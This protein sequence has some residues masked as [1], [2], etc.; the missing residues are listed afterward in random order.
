MVDLNIYWSRIGSFNNIYKCANS[1]LKGESS[2][3]HINKGESS[4][5]YMYKGKSSRFGRKYIFSNMFIIMAA[6]L[7]LSAQIQNDFSNIKARVNNKQ[8]HT[9]NSNILNF[10]VIW[11]NQGNHGKES[12]IQ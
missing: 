4:L 2:Y 5:Y 11:W 6:M 1:V 3:S 8:S 10:H 9:V 12:Q 7:L